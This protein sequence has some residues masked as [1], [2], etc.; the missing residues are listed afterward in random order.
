TLKKAAKGREM[1]DAGVVENWYGEQCRSE[2]GRHAESIQKFL[3]AHRKRGIK[4]E[5][6]RREFNAVVGMI[7]NHGILAYLRA[8]LWQALEEARAKKGLKQE[9]LADELRLAPSTYSKI[10]AGAT[11]FES[12]MLFLRPLGL[13]I[14]DLR[15]PPR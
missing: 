7:F 13:D 3:A 1:A 4:K 9:Q 15:L 2:F 6:P 5:E 12:I 14:R 11:N 8:S 10:Q